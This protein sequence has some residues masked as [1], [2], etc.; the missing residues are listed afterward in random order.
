[1]CCAVAIFS[2]A[3]LAS[4][5]ILSNP[6][7]VSAF[8]SFY[9][10]WTSWVVSSNAAVALSTWVTEANSLNLSITS[11]AFVSIS[12]KEFFKSF[13]LSSVNSI[14]LALFNSSAY[15]ITDCFN[16]STSFFYSSAPRFL[17]FIEPALD[18]QLLICFS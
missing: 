10:Y 6:S 11:P 2:A 4:A 9:N 7:G 8:N 5:S 1:L 3:S 12:F 17:I 16:L 18:V 15:F 14:L 13:N